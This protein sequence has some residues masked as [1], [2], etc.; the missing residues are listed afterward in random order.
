MFK[1][2]EPDDDD[3]TIT[4]NFGSILLQTLIQEVPLSN[5]QTDYILNFTLSLLQRSERFEEP[6]KKIAFELLCQL[7]HIR[8][9]TFDEKPHQIIL[10]WMK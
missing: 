9:F 5:E 1:Q 7:I 10:T 6:I 3:E 4:V 2:K 8:I